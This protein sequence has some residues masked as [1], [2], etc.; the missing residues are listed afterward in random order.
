[1]TIDINTVVVSILHFSGATRAVTRR[2]RRRRRRRTPRVGVDAQRTPLQRRGEGRA[3]SSRRCG[4]EHSLE[5]KCLLVEFG[6]T[7]I[8]VVAVVVVVVVVVSSCSTTKKVTKRRS[9]KF[10][11]RLGHQLSFPWF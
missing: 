5:A 1:M 8:R 4:V 7:P 3:F 11:R 10:A 9:A 2:M 6:D